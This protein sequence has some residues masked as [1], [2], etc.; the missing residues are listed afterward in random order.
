MREKNG[1]TLLLYTAGLLG[2]IYIILN[3][4][5]IH[6]ADSIPVVLL[7]I[8]MDLFPV[9]MLSGDDFSG[10][11]IGFMIL[12][13]G[14]GVETALMGI[15]LSTAIYFLKSSR[16]KASNIPF[17]R[18]I[19]TVGMYA[20]CMT[21][22]YISIRYLGNASV[23]IKSALGALIFETLNILLIAGIYKTV[24]GT[25]FLENVH[26]KIKE[27]V[28]PVLLCTVIVP[29]FL[30]HI[31]EN[32]IV[33]ETVYTSFFLIF[34]ILFSRGFLREAKLRKSS[35]EEFIRL[36]EFR[37]SRPSHGHG[38][39]LGIIAEYVLSKKGYTGRNKS[40]LLMSAILHDI[41]KVLVSSHVL[42]KRGALSLS[43]EKEYQSHS[44]KGAE[45]ILNITGNKE[46][47]DW[48]R[49]HHERYDGKGYPSGLKGGEIPLGSRIIALCNELDHLMLQYTNDEHVFQKVR[50]LSGKALDPI[51]VNVLDAAAIRS[52]RSQFVYHEVHEE[53]GN[54]AEYSGSAGEAFIGNTNLFKYF[55]E[56]QRLSGAPT[57]DLAHQIA[58][59]AEHSLQTGHTFHE[60]LQENGKTYETHFYPEQSQ[61]SIVMTDITAAIRYRD[62]LHENM[63]RSYKDVIET[64]SN[65]KVNICLTKEEVNDQLGTFI[66]SMDVNNKA[67]VGLSRSFVAGYYTDQ[68]DAK[69]LMHIKLAVSEGVTNLIKHAVGGEISLYDKQGTLQIFITDRGSGIPLHELPK[70]V[71]IPGYSS[72]RSLGKGFALIHASTDHISLHTNGKGTSLLLEFNRIFSGSGAAASGQDNQL[73]ISSPNQAAFNL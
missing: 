62:M 37:Q 70:T 73:T 42:N 39:R 19:S 36:C 2:F 47:A 44:E 1:F 12:L 11:I 58:H 13:L 16:W 38:S 34:I 61:V 55:A 66:A 14:F 27:T 54:E 69:R 7:I 46:V 9:K 24:S 22:T 4:D 5:H 63:M 3:T 25:N 26:F 10:G 17:F 23:Y 32:Q 18:F 30:I 50:E 35:S 72:K 71:L 45:I 48:I 64:L 33:Y 67:D 51:L 28:T 40:E 60:V 57:M 20:L 65:N 6:I 29:Y 8:L 49:Y 56:E 21:I 68:Q 41:G 53:S 15:Y 52:I 31:S 59:L 43:E